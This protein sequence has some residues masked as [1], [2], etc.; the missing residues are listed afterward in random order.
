MKHPK[1]PPQILRS[2]PFKSIYLFIFIFFYLNVRFYSG[3]E[4]I[5]CVEITKKQ[6]EGFQP[7]D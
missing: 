1:S 7:M 2:F 3:E 5:V 6:S 4:K